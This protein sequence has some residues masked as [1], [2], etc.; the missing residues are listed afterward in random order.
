[1]VTSVKAIRRVTPEMHERG[2]TT[3]SANTL[4]L[5]MQDYA[6]VSKTYPSE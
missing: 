5:N 4:S 2:Q 1:M 3:S 6:E